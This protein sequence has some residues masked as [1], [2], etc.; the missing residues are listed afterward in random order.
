MGVAYIYGP[1]VSGVFGEWIYRRIYD[2]VSFEDLR[3]EP[4]EV[5]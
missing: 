2:Y 4:G 3:K 1:G 5:L